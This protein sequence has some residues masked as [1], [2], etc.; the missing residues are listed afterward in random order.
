MKTLKKQNVITNGSNDS[1][2]RF[3]KDIRKEVLLTQ[4]EECELA[5]KIRQGDQAARDK[6]VK[7]NLR[8]VISVANQYQHSGISKEDLVEEGCIGL[9][10]AAEKFDESRGNKFITYAADWIRQSIGQAIANQ[11]N[12]VRIPINQV[13]MN[14]KIAKASQ[15]FEQETERKPSNKELAQLLDV[16][17]EKIEEAL[18]SNSRLFSLD[19]P[20]SNHESKTLLDEVP[21]AD[22]AP[23]DERLIRESLKHELQLL[24][25][26]LN[27]REMIVMRAVYGLDDKVMTYE[28]IGE[29]LGL[30]RERVRQIKKGAVR[31]L[32]KNS[33]NIILKSYLGK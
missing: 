18:K 14:N 24:M 15:K 25:N 9:I 21:N 31:K 33:D 32:R 27:K 23:T 17:E 10:K 5:A 19:A 29:Q 28:E 8:F 16:T 4:E 30:A 20:I 7:A 3:L 1:L 6:L 12:I 26:C 22:A 2:E 11:G 13:E